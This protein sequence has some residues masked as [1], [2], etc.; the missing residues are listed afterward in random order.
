M[1]ALK[2]AFK[3]S[4]DPGV[5]PALYFVTSKYRHA[6]IRRKIISLLSEAPGHK[7]VWDSAPIVRVLERYA[8]IEE[9]G[10]EELTHAFDIPDCNRLSSIDAKFDLEGRRTLVEYQRI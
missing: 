7:G 6:I 10:L 8:E 1:K 3:F 2:P 9:E 4:L 5:V